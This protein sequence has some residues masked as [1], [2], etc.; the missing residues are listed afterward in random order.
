MDGLWNRLGIKRMGS[1]GPSPRQY[2]IKKTVSVHCKQKSKEPRFPHLE[3]GSLFG[4]SLFELCGACYCGDI[5]ML[6]EYAG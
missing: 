6:E 4:P 1:L 2:I 5:R 3:L